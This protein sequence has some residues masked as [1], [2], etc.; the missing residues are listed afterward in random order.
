MM[1]SRRKRNKICTI[2]QSKLRIRSQQKWDGT[3]IEGYRK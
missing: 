1:V 3:G 2:K